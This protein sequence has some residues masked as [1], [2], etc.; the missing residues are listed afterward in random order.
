MDWRFQ[1][2]CVS[3]WR[4]ELVNLKVFLLQRLHCFATLHQILYNISKAIGG[5]PWHER[6]CVVCTIIVEVDFGCKS[7]DTDL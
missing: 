5:N 4:G 6:S 7:Q 1:G 2:Y 3:R